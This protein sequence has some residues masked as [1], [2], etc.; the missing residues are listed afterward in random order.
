MSTPTKPA[1][2]PAVIGAAIIVVVFAVYLTL[3]VG[4]GQSA[5][6]WVMVLLVL[7]LVN[8][9]YGAFVRRGK[10]T[11]LWCAT[12]TLGVLGV[13]TLTTIGGPVLLAAVLGG[14]SAT[15]ALPSLMPGSSPSHR[16]R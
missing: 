2:L 7:G 15:R 13:A 5:A 1:D 3:T 8:L 14:I 11:A 10:L 12:I 4:Q 6:P 9:L 16:P